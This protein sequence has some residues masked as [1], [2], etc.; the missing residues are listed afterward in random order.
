[1]RKGVSQLSLGAQVF[2]LIS[3]IIVG[4]E[5]IAQTTTPESEYKKLI[6]V[7]ED[8][9]P[10]GATPFGE[11]VSLYD[12]SLSFQVNDITV[13]GNGP[14]IT[15]G[16]TFKADGDIVLRQ[17]NAAFGDWDIDLPRLT[18]ITSDASTIIAG[19]PQQGWLVDSTLR[20]DRCTHIG[21]PPALRHGSP[22]SDLIP[23]EKWWNED[24]E[25]KIPGF[26]SQSV[27]LRA[28][29]S[30][31]APQMSGLT[32]VAATKDN[33]AIACLASTANGEDG[34]GFLA[35]SPDGTKYWLNQLVYRQ[36]R[37]FVVNRKM[38]YMLATRVEDRFGNWVTYTY[39]GGALQSIDA[40]DGRRVTFSY[41][42]DGT[43]IAQVNVVTSG[44][45]RSWTYQ[46]TTNSVGYT[47]TH[48]GLPDGSG[49][50][51]QFAD[52]AYEV[53]SEIPNQPTDCADPS[54]PDS[55]IVK[56]GTATAPSGLQGT[57]E[58]H[59]TGHARSDVPEICDTT[60]LTT[61]ARNYEFSPR[62]YN[63]LALTKKTFSGPGLTTA[64]VW[65]YTY[66]L[67][68]ATWHQQCVAGGCNY[69]TYAD[70]L[71][72]GNNVTRYTFSNRFDVTEGMAARTDY[73]SGPTVTGTPIRSEVLTYQATGPWPSRYGYNLID[74][75][76]TA[77]IT[78]NAPLAMQVVTQDGNTFTRQVLSFDAW[79]RQVRTQRYSN[80]SGQATLD[81]T[82][83][84]QDDY[85]RWVLG[86]PTTRVSNNAPSE[87][88]SNIEYD[89][90]SLMPLHRYAFGQ[91]LMTYGW[92]TAGQLTSF[93]DPLNHTTTLGNYKRGIP[94]SIGFPDST[95]ESLV[96]DDFGQIS[97]ITNQA[98]NST[99]YL[100]DA[101]GRVAE[102]DYPTGDSVA[103]AKQ[104]FTYS[105]ETWVSHGIA[106]N[107]WLRGVTQGPKVTYTYFDAMLRPIET[108]TR[109]SSDGGTP[110]TSRT[111]YDFHGN[112]IFQSYLTEGDQ[113]LSALTAGVTTNYDALS[114]VTSTVQPSEL[115]N[116]T[117]TTN[118]LS[119]ARKQ[120]I[121][122][123]GNSTTTSYQVFDEPSY[124]N[125]IQV[126]APEGVTQTIVRDIYG[127]PRSITQ[128][129]GGVT[130]VKKTMA[131]DSYY[132]LCRTKEP[133]SASEV[134]AYDAA[135]NLIWSASGQT[136]SGTD[137]ECGQSQVAAA[138]QTVR[139]YDAMNRVTA[140]TY[141]AGTDATAMTYT[142]TGKPLTATSGAVSW[143][144]GYNKLDLLT[145]EGL[146]VDGYTWALGYG[147][148]VNGV[149]AS[150]VYPDGKAVTYSPDFLGRPTTA[151]SYAAGATYYPD[152]GLQGFTFGSGAAYTATENSRNL[153]ANF[154]YVTAS[155]VAV[156]EDL[157]YDGNANITQV[158]D[159]TNNGQ[160]NKT[161]GYD[162]LNRLTSAN[163][164]NLW[165]TE[166]YTY[167]TLN[168]ITTLTTAG[169]TNT[170]NYDANTN[171]L[172]SVM[173]GATPVSTFSYDTRG[174]VTLRNSVPMVFDEANRL[175]QISGLDSYTYDAQGRRVKKTPVSGTPTYYAYNQA[176]QLMWQ[177]D[178]A[179]TNGT[180]YIYLGKKMV[181]ST[182][183]ADT[184]VIGN[185]DGVTTG[186]TATV[187]GWACSTGLPQSIQV[188]LYEG[189]AGTG[190][191]IAFVVANQ[192]S[193]AAI[194]ALCKSTGTA[195]RFSAV[196]SDSVRQTYPGQ[197]IYGYGASP[198]GNGDN[199]LTQS[200]VFTIPPSVNAPPAPAVL[201]AAAATDM[202]SINLSWS[203]AV[204]AT[205]YTLQES[206]NSGAW[207]TY[208]NGA[209]TSLNAPVSADGTY[210][211][212]VEACNTNGCSLFTSGPTVTI[213][214]T[215]TVP[216]AI[217]VPAT[218]SGPIAIGWSTTT[219]QTFYSL[220]QSFNGGA[221]AAI[222]NGAANAFSYT[223][224][225]TGT[226]TYRVRA[227]NASVC[228]GYGPTGSSTITIPP[229]QAPNIAVPATS[230]TGSYTVNWGGFAG[231]TS[232]VMQEQVN[233][234]GWTTIANN[235]SGTLNISGKGNGTYGY[236]VQGCN[237]GGCGPFSGTAS[238]VVN[239]PP[240][241]PANVGITYTY[242]STKK[243]TRT[244][245]W[246]LA[247]TATSY[248]ILDTNTGQTVYNS[249]S[250]A[251][252]FVVESAVPGHLP[253]HSYQIRACNTVGCSAWKNPDY[254]NE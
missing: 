17:G 54:L 150:T 127:N 225:S 250:T 11:S 9:N 252:S 82:A 241:Q 113:A 106:A 91:L 198:V 56:T 52:L 188:G 166:S 49:W 199:M 70:V 62:Y 134:M 66:P 218:S 203:S 165:G 35:V 85:T 247:A 205:S 107:H 200:G 2:L 222:Y 185:I 170:Y 47:L 23:A 76:N 243:E 8:I 148:D 45:S 177:Y 237:A 26:G 146:S 59:P 158:N 29:E 235:G 61:P 184:T 104:T 5:V 136:I 115:G 125:V 186:T 163:A 112:K 58:T 207:A 41:T 114:R 223:A 48:V 248:Q 129:G 20:T 77:K 101:I 139:G 229:T 167:D 108:L 6:K 220:E 72:P 193:E 183:K 156:S 97:S 111:D 145:A 116:L 175:T 30:P 168:N 27:L 73:Y 144:Y 187:T 228:G 124:D 50:S 219:Y 142:L 78:Q 74:F 100:Y 75:L 123:K 21:P 15:V 242:V 240:P 181:A 81:E 159:L 102:I 172:I 153:L 227:C 246:N 98:G 143:T 217:S 34:E 37:G 196:L 213:I 25:L 149:L 28:P 95:S 118:Y 105:F 171:R 180:D 147:Y 16:R 161:L 135:N 57:F 234:G 64:Q 51:Y 121:D 208:Y 33:W 154:S 128:S 132:R 233:G 238:V 251:T 117:T 53:K 173:N 221:F 169:V 69:T 179:T 43:Q 32:F 209:A 14:L 88:E 109:R 10:L 110:K 226:Y 230:N 162:G 212:R 126:S 176:G 204:T 151:G 133:E 236:R 87:T 38:G 122:P 211:W 249:T 96:V 239:V 206:Y 1:M 4:S 194:N 65:S 215:P 245:T 46:Y 44:G 7:D 254:D 90:T 216:T 60:S 92:N 80:V 244:M 63:N 152:G 36:A 140:I 24:Y 155:A 210:A 3:M 19:P 103:W 84:Y 189:P 138:A 79:A 71:D 42:P 178:P 89:A 191:N 83:G 214:H 120:V 174:N 86:L 195:Y 119:G 12:G 93:T 31:T 39:N 130:P 164:S 68:T 182:V 141:P 13:R 197:P 157:A 67:A 160:R 231:M 224:T 253:Y 232:Y 137:D 22:G 131:Y 99:S 18:T 94:Q 192:S 201:N 55:S 190:A 202:N 40:S